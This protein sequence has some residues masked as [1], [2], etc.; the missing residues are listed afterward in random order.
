[1][2]LWHDFDSQVCCQVSSEQ[3]WISLLFK[4]IFYQQPHPEAFELLFNSPAS[5]SELGALCRSQ[6]AVSAQNHRVKGHIS[7]VAKQPPAASHLAISADG[8]NSDSPLCAHTI[9][10]F[11]PW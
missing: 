1:M 9:G 3:A 10:I 6:A 8:G 5:R 4:V 2:Y 7:V 11:G